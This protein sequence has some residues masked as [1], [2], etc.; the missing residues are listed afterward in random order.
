MALPANL[1]KCLVTGTFLT[2]DGTPIPNLKVT[3]QPDP[4][5]PVVQDPGASTTFPT[6][7]FFGMTDD[8]GVL[9]SW[10]T[11]TDGTR[12]QI[13]GIETAFPSDADLTQKNWSYNALFEDMV[14]GEQTRLS[15]VPVAGTVDLSAATALDAPIWADDLRTYLDTLAQSRAMRDEIMQWSATTF[16]QI[17][18]IS[19]NGVPGP[20]GEV[21]PE[22]PQGPA[23][24]ASTAIQDTK[25]GSASTAWPSRRTYREARQRTNLIPNGMGEWGEAGD[26]ATGLD[27][28]TAVDSVPP[29]IGAAFRFEYGKST[30][31]V[32]NGSFFPVDPSIP[33]LYTFWIKADKPNS[34]MYIECRGQDGLHAIV[35]GAVPTGAGYFVAA[36]TVPT[37]WTKYT[38]VVRFKPTTTKVRIAGIHHNHKGGP[39]Q[40][41]SYNYAHSLTPLYDNATITALSGDKAGQTTSVLSPGMR[42]YLSDT[43]ETFEW[44][45]TKWIDLTDTGWIQ[46]T[47][48]DSSFTPQ[49]MGSLR[50]LSVR[51]VGRQVF[52]DGF[53]ATSGALSNGQT[54]ATLPPGTYP[55]KWSLISGVEYNPRTFA[56]FNASPGGQI[57]AGVSG[58]ASSR[59]FVMSANWFID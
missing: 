28:V 40:T 31:G 51:R 11:E 24:T 43:G 10:R 29:D 59:G 42:F 3:I 54:M 53:I 32:N 7:E 27:Y 46:V 20:R 2:L 56:A 39:E 45:G 36:L 6:F 34:R 26:W 5:N 15:F 23:G 55:S 4:R 19:L 48:A 30:T 41:A 35:G 37:T 21:G 57:Q 58:S 25:E 18:D 47:G 49:A 13:T 14:T 8:K 38:R 50:P 52:L 16:E 44:D 17:K 9:K 12:T 1:S 33:Y 22:G